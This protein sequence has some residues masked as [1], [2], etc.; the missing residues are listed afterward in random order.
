MLV[1]LNHEDNQRLRGGV[2]RARPLRDRYRPNDRA[3]QIGLPVRRVEDSFDDFPAIVNKAFQVRPT[4]H[5][6][7]EVSQLSALFQLPQIKIILEMTLG[8]MIWPTH[9]EENHKENL[10]KIASK[11]QGPSR[12]R[13]AFGIAL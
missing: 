12:Y 1:R 7:F 11:E 8:W 3:L 5:G 2:G 10:D 4:P 13:E 6:D 9:R